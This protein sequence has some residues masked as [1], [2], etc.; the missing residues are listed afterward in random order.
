MSGR[1]NG[2]NGTKKRRT[3]MSI[4]Y[5]SEFKTQAFGDILELENLL[6]KNCG[7][8]NDPSKQIEPIPWQ[9]EAYV[10]VADGKSGNVIFKRTRHM[11]DGGDLT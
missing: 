9:V 4:L 8:W 2:P 6:N 1:K 5:K 10:Y 7:G 11:A 3:L